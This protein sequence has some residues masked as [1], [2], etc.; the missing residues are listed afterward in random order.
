MPPEN[1]KKELTHYFTGKISKRQ[2]L[3][4]PPINF[5]KFFKELLIAL[6]KGQVL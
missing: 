4:N 1:I 5:A 2:D 3:Q 6:Q